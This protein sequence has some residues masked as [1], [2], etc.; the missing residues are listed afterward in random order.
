MYEMI[1]SGDILIIQAAFDD[2][3]KFIAATGFK[4]EEH[5]TID[6]NTIESNDS[7]LREVTVKPDSPSIGMN[8]KD[9]Q[10]RSSFG[11]NLLAVSRQGC[12]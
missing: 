4:L 9:I 6:R 8:V 5:V 12:S 1:K 11:I 7:I 2:L 10:L 3:Q